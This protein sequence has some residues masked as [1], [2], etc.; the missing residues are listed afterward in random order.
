MYQPRD[1]EIEEMSETITEAAEAMLD[2]RLILSEYGFQRLAEPAQAELDKAA[3]DAPAKPPAD[4][5]SGILVHASELIAARGVERDLPN[6]E[7]SMARCVEA[8]NAMTGHRLR[9]TDGWLFMVYLKHARSRGGRFH[10]DDYRDAVAY[11]G[12]RAEC[13][14]KAEKEVPA[15]G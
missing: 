10:E 3:A 1:E 11:E 6:G 7:R 15:V 4:D 5:A 2:P 14:F 8:F 13:A 12:L 9:E